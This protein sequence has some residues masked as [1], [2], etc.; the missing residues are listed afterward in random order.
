MVKIYRADY[1]DGELEVFSY[2]E[3]DDEAMR[4]AESYESEHGIVFNLFELNEDFEEI[5]TVY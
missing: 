2:C 4:E 5:R 3:N 1:E